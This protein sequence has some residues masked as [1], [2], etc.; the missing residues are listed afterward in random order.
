MVFSEKKSD[1]FKKISKKIKGRLCVYRRIVC[2]DY[3]SGKSPMDERVK[4]STQLLFLLFLVISPEKKG[5]G[6]GT[7]SQ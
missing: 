5:G 1:F 4:K 3:G 6:G 7:F 2:M